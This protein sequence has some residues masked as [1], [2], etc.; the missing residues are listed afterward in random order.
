VGLS[1]PT[2][3][4]TKPFLYHW[5]IDTSRTLPIAMDGYDSDGDG[6]SDL[7]EL[8][9]QGDPNDPLVGPGG[10]ECPTGPLPEYG[11]VRIARGPSVPDGWA[12]LAAALPALLLLRRRRSGG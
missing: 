9:N 5:A 4:T 8:M 1:A 11:C 12:L 3:Y 7:D 2:E 10:F 6:A